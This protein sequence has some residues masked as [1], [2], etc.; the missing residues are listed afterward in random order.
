MK[1]Y[2]KEKIK[3]IIEEADLPKNTKFLGY[4]IH[5]PKNDEYLFKTD[6]K[7]LLIWS[8]TPQNAIKFKIYEKACDIVKK[9]SR[10]DLIICIV[11]DIGKQLATIPDHDAQEIIKIHQ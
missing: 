8:K 7:A 6:N 10:G 11:L 9:F 3:I 1:R 4:V 5:L 2:N